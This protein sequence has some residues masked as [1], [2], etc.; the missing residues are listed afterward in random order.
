[1]SARRWIILIAVLLAGYFLSGVHQIR[2]GERGVVRR[3]GRVKRE[4][5]GKGTV[6][7]QF[8]SWMLL[9]PIGITGLW[10]GVFH[11]F[12]PAAAAAYIGWQVSPFQFEVGMADLAITGG[13]D[14]H[15]PENIRRPIGACTIC[16]EELETL[17]QKALCRG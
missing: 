17:R 14:C 2:P 5:Y 13:S 4:Y 15:G 12:F 8:L 16:S 10:A 9:L 11:I 3:F 1:M 7:E 6:A